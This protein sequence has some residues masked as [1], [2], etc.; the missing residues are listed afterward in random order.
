MIKSL[1][2]LLRNL[3]FTI[4]HPGLVAG[5]IPYW[6]VGN[7]V[8][9]SFAKSLRVQQYLGILLF[10]IGSVVLF[11][12][13]I[14]FAIEGRGT[15]SPADPTKRLVITGLYRYSRNPM[16]WG[17]MLIL[18]GEATYFESND[19]WIYL[20]CVFLFFNLFIIRIE[21]P[22]LRRDFGEDYYQYCQKV[23][24]WV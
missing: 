3:F 1:S 20:V 21:E 23:R 5:L 16:Y 4:L 15:L 10:I 8:V 13:I 18:I 6:I 19:L 12:C 24:R 22:R 2:L 11:N 17:V 9:K 7:K 14:R